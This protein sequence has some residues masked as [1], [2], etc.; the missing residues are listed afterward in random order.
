MGIAVNQHQP[1]IFHNPVFPA[2][3]TAYKPTSSNQTLVHERVSDSA[4]LLNKYL[5]GRV[6]C[7]SGD[8]GVGV[9]FDWRIFLCVRCGFMAFHG[10]SGT[11]ARTCFASRAGTGVKKFE[12]AARQADIDAL[13]ACHQ[14]WPDQLSPVPTASRQINNG[15]VRMLKGVV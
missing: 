14:A 1:C 6:E 4:P 10:H 13:H 8:V 12:H 3:P 9:S 7:S 5:L 15:A 2:V 11:E